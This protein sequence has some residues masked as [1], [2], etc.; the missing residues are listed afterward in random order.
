[1]EHKAKSHSTSPGHRYLSSE[2]RAKRRYHKTSAQHMTGAPPG[3]PT[4]DGAPSGGAPGP[5]AVPPQGGAPGG[6]PGPDQAVQAQ[7]AAAM[8]MPAGTSGQQ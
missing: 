2:E 5:P 6:A 7:A 1:M 4:G 3:Q 8:G